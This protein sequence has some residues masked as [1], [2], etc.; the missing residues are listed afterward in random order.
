M[1]EYLS[2]E[3]IIQTVNV[4]ITKYSL[5]TATGLVGFGWIAKKTKSTWDDK[6]YLWLKGK[7]GK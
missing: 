7:L 4:M 2:N 3:Y 6:V 5:A 1:I